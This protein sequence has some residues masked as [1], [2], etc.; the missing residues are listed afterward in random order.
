MPAGTVDA[1]R[2]LFTWRFAASVAALVALALLAN[3]VFA[4]EDELEAVVADPVVTRRVDLVVGVERF[5]RSPDFTILDDGTTSGILDAVIDGQRTMR[6]APGTEGEISCPNLRSSNRCVVLADLLGEAVLWFAI[7]PRGPN[8]TIVLGP[9]RD[10]ED[11]YAV[12]ENGW[13]I[14]FADVIERDC[15]DEDIPTFS[16][17]L[18]R[19]GPNS[20][21]IVDLETQLVDEVVCG[22]EV[23][24]A[25][26]TT[27]EVQVTGP[28]GGPV[29]TPDQPAGDTGESDVIDENAG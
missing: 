24:P 7:V 13:E 9:I 26:T 21:S 16:D 25:A 20:T 27:L 1:V 15:G 19:F 2:Q 11:G 29:V 8:N 18:A 14:P 23:A 10:L 6:I 3:A 28:A 4:G 22:D 5:E 12:F 17:F